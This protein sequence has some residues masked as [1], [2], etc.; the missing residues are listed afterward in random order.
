MWIRFRL[1]LFWFW[2]W[3][4][5]CWTPIMAYMQR[6]EERAGVQQLA[7]IKCLKLSSDVAVTMLLSRWFHSRTVCTKKEILYWSVRLLGM[8]KGLEFLVAC[9]FTIFVVSQLS[10]FF[11]LIWRFAVF[12]G[13]KSLAVYTFN[14]HIISH[15][16]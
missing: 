14:S 3:L 16:K 9:L 11:A 15:Y 10:N 13:V 4:I 12:L 2:F 1:E 5:R 8:L 6:W 7:L